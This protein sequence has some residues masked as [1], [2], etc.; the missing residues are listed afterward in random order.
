MKITQVERQKKNSKRFNIYLDGKFAFGADEDTLVSLRLIEGKEITQEDLEKILLETEVGKL[1]DRV[2]G[3]LSRRFRSEREIRDYLK[4]LSFKRKIKDREELSEIVTESLIEKL[5]QRDLINDKRFAKEWVE[6]RGKKRGVQV[7]K[8]ELIQK[9]IDR[10]IIEEVISHQSSAI[11]QEEVAEQA[12]DKKMKS[13]SNLDEI[14]LKKKAT[15][16]LLR[17]GFGYQVARIVIEK[18]LKKE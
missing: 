16:Y 13:F 17:R 10:E 5:K 4:E 1:V 12:L 2:Y 14:N 8:G 9:G 6:S 11:S 15:E 3:L 18:K 7:L